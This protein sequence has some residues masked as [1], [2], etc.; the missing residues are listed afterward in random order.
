[1]KLIESTFDD[2]HLNLA[3]EEYVFQNFMDDDYFIIWENDNSIALGKYQNPFEEVNFKE[4]EKLGTKIARRNSG[5]GTVFHDKGNINYSVIIN[6]E[7]R[8]R[9]NYDSFMDPI[10]NSLNKLGIKAEKTGICN[11]VV[12]DKK[13]SGNAQYSRKGRV[14]HHGTLLYD[15]NLK[16]LNNILTPTDGK[17]ESKSV[18]SV[19][20]HVTNIIDY[21]DKRLSLSNFKSEFLRVLFPEGIE[22]VRFSDNQEQEVFDLAK[23]KYMTWEWTYGNTPDFTLEKTATL[24]DND[25]DI[26]LQIKKGRIASVTLKSEKLSWSEIEK[27]LIDK[28]YSYK[29][30]FYVLKEIKDLEFDIEELADCFF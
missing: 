22:R 1:M 21:M 4:V 2:I 29:E 6:N 30:V 25:F 16:L 14:L 12:D 8:L 11:I 27:K 15:A 18:K 17:I 23:D 26:N 13:I 10:I 24:D 9:V 7:K 28:K 5:G 3:L 20:S 19:K